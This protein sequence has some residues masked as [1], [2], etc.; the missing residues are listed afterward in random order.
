MIT[1]ISVSKQDDLHRVEFIFGDRPVVV[2]I[3]NEELEGLIQ[4]LTEHH[5]DGKFKFLK[6]FS[7]NL[8]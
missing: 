6:F 7:V 5:T 3:T 2:T 8:N 4:I 1:Q